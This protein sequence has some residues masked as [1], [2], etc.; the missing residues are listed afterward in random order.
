M[1][2]KA[3]QTILDMEPL[4]ILP[5]LVLV[6]I[7]QNGRQSLQQHA[8]SITFN[9]FVGLLEVMSATYDVYL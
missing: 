9:L 7:F 4:Q 1:Y 3:F 6:A 5:C 8:I 2:I